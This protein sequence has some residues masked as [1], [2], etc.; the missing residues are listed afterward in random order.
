[1]NILKDSDFKKAFLISS[2]ILIHLFY[3]VIVD[4]QSSIAL[5]KY[6]FRSSSPDN[7]FLIYIIELFLFV[8][9]FLILYLTFKLSK[10][11]NQLLK[12]VVIFFYS[13]LITYF[14]IY[15]LIFLGF[16]N[17]SGGEDLSFLLVLLGWP[18]YII[19]HL[20]IMIVIVSIIGTQILSFKKH[21][22][23]NILP[24]LPSILGFL[25]LTILNLTGRMIYEPI[26]RFKVKQI[27]SKL[28]LQPLVIRHEEIYND[29]CKCKI[30]T[31]VGMVNIDNQVSFPIILTMKKNY[32]RPPAS[33]LIGEKYQYEVRKAKQTVEFNCSVR[34]PEQVNLDQAQYIFILKEENNERVR[35]EKAFFISDFQDIGK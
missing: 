33:C 28:Q 22:A 32:E 14:I 6:S 16:Y 34:Y 29:L 24:L 27:E 3:S 2:I 5:Q 20:P 15:Q 26:Y 35:F 13:L 19:A 17:K 9:S 7:R 31:I 11:S 1:M 25:V 4:I 12:K 23:P 30:P 18:L 8:F 10:N 21:F